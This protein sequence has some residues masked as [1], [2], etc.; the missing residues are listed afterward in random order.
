MVKP[1]EAKEPSKLQRQLAGQIVKHIRDDHLA[2]G[3]ALTEIGLAE[4][5]KVSRTPVRAALEYLA[6]QGIVDSES[7]RGFSV[8]RSAD[9]LAAVELDDEV[10]D[11]DAL[12]LRIAND[13]MA[14][15]LEDHFSEADLMRRYQVRRG[16]LTRVLQ[17]M[18][19]DFVIERNQG[20]GWSFAPLVKS[21]EAHD[22]SYRFR[23]V[24]EPAAILEPGYALDL[25]WAERCRAA[26]EAILAT[27]PEKLSPIHFF[28]VNADFHELVAAGS[29]N[30][31]FLQAVQQQNRLRRFLGY[32]W[33]Y[34]H[35]RIV[36]SCVEHLDVLT[37]L[38]KG[39]YEW[40][41]TL[42]RRHLELAARIKPESEQPD[43]EKAAA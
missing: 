35:E 38:E 24:I 36:E 19:R 12:Y 16:L 2:P 42:M 1:A 43:A 15:R 33:T 30:S 32:N 28:E 17:R 34:G 5:F 11:D 20:H 39:E 10:S 37:A 26:H 6:A 13:F 25:R 3:S 14:E 31:F 9:E 7:R 21:I 8:A 22:E 4:M 40:A 41:S 29:H 23:L 18:A 27:P